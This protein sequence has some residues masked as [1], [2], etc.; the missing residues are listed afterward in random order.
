VDV[1]NVVVKDVIGV[2]AVA[3]RTR[4]RNVVENEGRLLLV[5][6]VLLFDDMIDNIIILSFVFGDN[7]DYEKKPLVIV[8]VGQQ[9][10]Y[11]KRIKKNSKETKDSKIPAF[12][13]KLHVARNNKSPFSCIGSRRQTTKI[14]S[15]NN[16]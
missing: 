12:F 10:L 11:E 8:L 1:V 15:R 7:C 2:V 16:S 13:L 9:L 6:C 3:T 5:V 4:R 14:L